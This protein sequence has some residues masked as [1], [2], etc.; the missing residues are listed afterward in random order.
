MRIEG[1]LTGHF[2]LRV[3]LMLAALGGVFLMWIAALAYVTYDAN[4]PVVAGPAAIVKRVAL[5]ATS[6]DGT[7]TLP[8]AAMAE[9][10]RGGVWVQVLDESGNEV[11]STGRPATMPTRYSPGKLVLYRQTP[12]YG[13]S[14]QRAISTWLETVGGREYTFVAGVPGK[15][16]QGPSILLNNRVTSPSPGTVLAMS[17]ALLV[18]GAVAT[19]GV[20]WLFGHGLSRPLVHMM[21]WLS[22]LA[23]GRYAEPVG[24]SGRPA[25]RGRDGTALRRPYATYREVFASLDALTAEL[26]AMEE[27]RGRIEAARDEWIAG[28][29]HDLRTPLTSIRGYAEVLASDYEFGPD[30]VRRQAGVVAEQAGHMDELLDDLDLSFRLR[31]DAI[32]LQ[33]EPVDLVEAAREAAAGLANDPRAAESRVSFE[34]PAG[35]GAIRVDADPAL[36]RRAL[37]NLLV[38][39]AIHN[40]PGTK[41]T[42]SVMREGA[43]AIVRVDDDGVGMDEATRARLFDRYFRGTGTGEETTGTGLGLAIARQIIEAH[44]GTIEVTTAPGEGTSVRIELPAGGPA[45]SA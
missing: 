20:A 22:S 15:P 21:D 6:L 26:R 33:W 45:P 12:S 5:G 36:L 34:E 10:R 38:N 35:A 13:G 8:A 14:G 28:V 32:A 39:A 37:A 24:R 43:R 29:S 11:T 19:L 31:A 23:R 2:L 42:V 3:A 16:A 25:S 44:R 18:G 41:V 9:A 40:P 30:E 1:R 17:L 7:L 27:E 4:A